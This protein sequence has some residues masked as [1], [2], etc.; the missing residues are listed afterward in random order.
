MKIFNGGV[1][2]MAAN[3]F[4]FKSLS[5]LKK[6]AESYRTNLVSNLQT[7]TNPVY[8]IADV[9]KEEF[10]NI[11]TFLYNAV[12]KDAKLIDQN[13]STASLE[14]SS[15]I[16]K[17]FD[18]GLSL[19]DVISLK[20]FVQSYNKTA[21]TYMKNNIYR[22][23]FGIKTIND[24]SDPDSFIE[25]LK[26]SLNSK[27]K[28]LVDNYND[29]TTKK[30]LQ[31]WMTGSA[32]LAIA[33]YNINEFYN[34]YFLKTNIVEMIITLSII[35]YLNHSEST[36]STKGIFEIQ[37]GV[38]ARN[39]LRIF[40]TEPF[41][42]SNL[43]N[44]DTK[45]FYFSN[46]K[47]FIE[48]D[49]QITATQTTEG[50][51]LKSI[52]IKDSNLRIITKIPYALFTVTSV[53]AET[54]K[55]RYIF[56]N[57][58]NISNNQISYF[59]LMTD[60]RNNLISFITNIDISDE[61]E[62]IS[63]IN[64]EEYN[65]NL[66]Y[67]ILNNVGNILSS[68]TTPIRDVSRLFYEKDRV[69]D[70]SYITT[71]ESEKLSPEFF[72]IRNAQ[73]GHQLVIIDL[74]GLDFSNST[75]LTEARTLFGENTIGDILTNEN[76]DPV[77]VRLTY[78]VIYKELNPLLRSLCLVDVQEFKLARLFSVF[79]YDPSAILDVNTQENISYLINLD[80]LYRNY[81]ETNEIFTLDDN[82]SR[83]KFFYSNMYISRISNESDIIGYYVGDNSSEA[84]FTNNYGSKDYHKAEIQNF[85]DIYKET[86]E[87]YYRVLLNKSFIQ[88]EMYSL[89]EKIFIGF[90]AIERF[91]TGKLD[92]LRDPEFFNDTDIYN[93]LESY[94]LGVLNQYDFFLGSRNYKTN[95]IKNFAALNKAKGSKD[96][97]NLLAT[98]F[99]VGDT[100]VDINKFLLV[101]EVDWDEQNT[102]QFD[103]TTRL[104]TGAELIY[105][106]NTNTNI[107]LYDTN[108][109]YRYNGAFVKADGDSVTSP[110]STD[111]IFDEENQKL[112]NTLSMQE[113]V[114]EYRS[115]V[116]SSS[117]QG[118]SSSK[119]YFNEITEVFYLEATA[120]THTK[121]SFVN[122]LP[123][124]FENGSIIYNRNIKKFFIIENSNYISYKVYDYYPLIISENVG[125]TLVSTSSIY[126][127]LSRY[128][129]FTFFTLDNNTGLLNG[130]FEYSFTLNR[131]ISKTYTQ[132]Q[133]LPKLPYTI[134]VPFWRLLIKTG[135]ITRKQYND[136][137]PMLYYLEE[138][139]QNG[140]RVFIN[141]N[142]NVGDIFG[143]NIDNEINLFIVPQIIYN[144]GLLRFVEV[145]Y[146]SDNGTRELNNNLSSGT[147]YISFLEVSD[148]E[149]IDPYW[150]K[151]NVP[152]SVLLDIGIDSVETKF[153]S[154]I[155][156]ENIYRRYVIS[157]YMLS[158][159]EFL[160][161]FII[162]S[163]VN[164]LN[165][166]SVVERIIVDSGQNL[167]GE[168]SIY[169][170]YKIV[171]I[172]FK[173]LLRLYSANIGDIFDEP[174]I[175]SSPKF[176]GINKDYDWSHITSFLSSK[177]IGFNSV[178][179]E[180]LTESVRKNT[181]VETFNKFNLYKKSEDW[182]EYDLDLEYE[183][184]LGYEENT[185]EYNT[186]AN[187]LKNSLFATIK[188]DP[189]K[190]QE[191]SGDYILNLFENLN[192]IRISESDGEGDKPIA[193]RWDNLWSYFLS[194]Y[195]DNKYDIAEESNYLIQKNQSLP[196]KEELYDNIINSI[197]KM[198]I[199]YF[200]GILNPAYPD[201]ENINRNREFI[202]LME[203]ILENVYIVDA[204]KSWKRLEVIAS[205]DEPSNSETIIGDYWF[206]TDATTNKLRIKTASSTWT[207]VEFQETSNTFGVNFGDL[208]YNEEDSELFVL[209]GEDPSMITD[210][211]VWKEMDVIFAATEPTSAV[212]GDYWFDTDAEELYLKASNVFG[213]AISYQETDE[214]E[215]ALNT[216]FFD[217][218]KNKFYMMSEGYSFS[219]EIQDYL[220]DAIAI[221]NGT[222]PIQN[223]TA[224]EL[225]AEILL[226]SEK[227]INV[228]G[229][230]E[231]VFPS[232]PF[233]QIS[234]SLKENEQKTLG[235][236][237]T[238]IKIFLSYTS[239][240]YS[241]RFV[242]EYKTP[243]ESALMHEDINHTLKQNKADYVFSD[244]K[245]EIK[246]V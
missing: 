192:A 199:E 171:K 23:V 160:E 215:S 165:K 43:L 103:L 18:E 219:T 178:S 13:E 244:E 88:D 152:E 158:T 245:L 187:L 224:A 161:N 100:I 193:S 220:E 186:V 41:Y 15:Y 223:L 73:S 22:Y 211:K 42:S 209:I 163:E 227:L 26:L 214:I 188:T 55:E 194:K 218:V 174:N 207:P 145:P 107:K 143:Y 68:I 7:K 234:F 114:F 49:I 101:E 181:T 146:S 201:T 139:S 82:L 39:P 113:Q 35:S 166:K 60:L 53:G 233:M 118:Y 230:L 225:D 221:A 240:L 96:V 21:F 216:I 91:L 85:L 105:D 246:E 38:L 235:F 169:N 177:I 67:F 197:M 95:I 198:P 51:L 59:N 123:K 99:D 179:S 129:G 32:G 159:I 54:L 144:T 231:S 98:I 239:Q 33:K 167:F 131:T 238:A 6:M 162:K 65:F 20:T 130:L 153:L 79:N 30:T 1:D 176:Y 180:F 27:I 108:R 4:L 183:K 92:N 8:T 25:K 5:D 149:K 135:Y 89:Y 156:S 40:E 120:K 175:G 200:D 217:S 94:G 117:E 185:K 90:F 133:E 202:Q 128:D 84:S 80:A 34:N 28:Y 222:E 141:I 212:N 83:Y 31:S 70:Y 127:S 57:E 157:R 204:K 237:E 184:D 206:D 50:S 19:R 77:V 147:P 110:P 126:Q 190:I 63:G 72:E 66:N 124:S 74:K 93:F 86:R 9:S 64:V 229:S 45:D 236:V 56:L 71:T 44:I 75:A 46:E 191:N 111:Y 119:I 121:V 10:D 52:V 116:P 87:Y 48:Q 62:N 132:V 12:V 196:S 2:K 154:L 97:I 37:S 115:T 172:L 208:Y 134:D 36:E 58:S 241:S 47:A 122:E 78:T 109:I 232:Q 150:T 81:K 16:T 3:N 170:Y 104:L 142:E 137:S 11:S 69:I 210:A 61:V 203:L 17:Y 164:N 106:G 102:S 195:F 205:D 125:K 138:G 243:S 24:D 76:G 151:E 242:R 182:Q 226:Y 168:T 155:V 136:K 112:Y 148:D 29:R 173:T 213:S 140:N 14:F 189:S 228:L